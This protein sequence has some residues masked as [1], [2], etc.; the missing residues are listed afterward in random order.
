M[1]FIQLSWSTIMKVMAHRYAIVTV[2][3]ASSYARGA[4][5]DNSVIPQLIANLQAC[6]QAATN[7]SQ[8]VAA[9]LAQNKD[10]EGYLATIRKSMLSGAASNIGAAV[11]TIIISRMSWDVYNRI[12]AY[13]FS[14]PE[15]QQRKKL[16]YD[17]NLLERTSAVLEKTAETG[18]TRSGLGGAPSAQA[19][20]LTAARARLH[21][22]ALSLAE[23]LAV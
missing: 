8:N 17:L 15:Q 1:I 14:S 13:F 19:Q 3:L 7:C 21:A 5:P 16:I 22:Q 9:L 4:Q 2:L 18:I 20:K 23:R 11:A 10:G 6:T 12:K